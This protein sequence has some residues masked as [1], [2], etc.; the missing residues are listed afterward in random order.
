MLIEELTEETKFFTNLSEIKTAISPN[1]SN[2]KLV[3]VPN[4]SNL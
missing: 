4:E 2:K 1:T 3:T